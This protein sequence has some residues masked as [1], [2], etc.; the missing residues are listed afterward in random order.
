M[1]DDHP[2]LNNTNINILSG[3]Y[4]LENNACL[5]DRTQ[6]TQVMSANVHFTDETLID[7]Y[8]LANLCLQFCK[9]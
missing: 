2:F 1:I 9:V 3:Q 8:H 5:N 4:I 7:L 6:Y